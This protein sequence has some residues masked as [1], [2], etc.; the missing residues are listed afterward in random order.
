MRKLAF[1]GLFFLG[2]CAHT[3]AFTESTKSVEL[4]PDRCDA[5]YCNLGKKVIWE[6]YLYPQYVQ[7]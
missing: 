1:L 4:S 3:G 6:E 7:R 5:T 2:G